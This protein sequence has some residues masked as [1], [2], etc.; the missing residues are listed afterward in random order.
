[1][2]MLVVA[3]DVRGDVVESRRL[4]VDGGW[5]VRVGVCGAAGGLSFRFRYVF[6]NESRA[7]EHEIC[8][9]THW[10]RLLRIGSRSYF[11]EV[12]KAHG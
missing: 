9:S 6:Q 7:V 3:A 5:G 12:S 4:G 10:G 8:C 1:M 11:F 2:G